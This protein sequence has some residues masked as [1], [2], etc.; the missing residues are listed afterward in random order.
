VT[1]PLAVAAPP[2]ALEFPL[3]E[4]VAFAPSDDFHNFATSHVMKATARK[5][6]V[7]T[8]TTTQMPLKVLK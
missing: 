6:A 4:T 8:T 1:L 5:R 7:V 2:A 3:F